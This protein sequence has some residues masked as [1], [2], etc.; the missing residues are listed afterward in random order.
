[1]GRASQVQVDNWNGA[2]LTQD[3][4]IRN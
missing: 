2:E 3:T 1:V 4:S